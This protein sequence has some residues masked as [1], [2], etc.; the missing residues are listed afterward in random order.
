VRGRLLLGLLLLA[1]LGLLGARVEVT[2][3]LG[4]LLPDDGELQQAMRDVQ[5]FRLADTVL[6]EVDGTGEERRA[7]LAATDDL[8]ERLRTIPQIGAVRYRVEVDDGVALRAVALPHAA[9]LLPREVLAERLSDAGLRRALSLQLQ[10]LAGPGGSLFERSFLEDPLDLGGLT[11][12]H[13]RSAASPFAIRVADGHFLDMSGTRALITLQPEVPALGMG[14]DHPLIAALS[15]AVDAG[16]LPARWFGGHRLSSEAAGLIHKDVARSVQIGSVLLIGVCL[17]GF[18]SLRPVLG[19]A[20]PVG[21]ASAAGAAAAA[22]LSPVHGISLGFSAALLGLAIDYW[23]HLYVAA[24]AR[25]PEGADGA[26]RRAAAREALEE[27]L[28]GLLIG[29]GSTAGACAVLTLSRY[30][31]VADLGWMGVAATLGALA[32][33]VLLGPPMFGLIGRRRAA[34]VGANSA[35]IGALRVVLGSITLA[36][37][38]GATDTDVDGDPRHLAPAMAETR[39][40]EEEL[41]ARYGGFGTGGLAVVRGPDLEAVTDRLDAVQRALDALPGVDAVGPSPVLPGPTTRA[42]RRAALPDVASLQ[43]RVDSA[44]AALGFAPAALAGV[45][46][47]AVSLPA[48]TLSPA[49]W[50]QTPLAAL[51][52]QRLLPDGTG[53]VI[54]VVLADDGLAGVAE[55]AV[56]AS[57]GGEAA[58]V[59]TGGLA[60]DGVEDILAELVRL[61]GLSTA[62]VLGLLIA[63]Y[64]EPRKV[65][66]AAAPCAVA[67]VWALGVMGLTGTPWNAVS[68]CGLIFVLGLGLDHGVFMVEG[69]GRGRARETGTAVLLSALTTIGGFAALAFTQSPALFGLGL[70]VPAGV[71][72]ALATA[73]AVVPALT[74]GERVA[75]RWLR[76][77]ALAVLV[78]VDL[79]LIAQQLFYLTPPPAGP[80]PDDWTLTTPAPGDRRLGPN[81]LLQAGGI[82]TQ[83][84][85]G[86]AYA[87]GYAGAVLAP[88]LRERLEKQTLVSFS[89]NVPSFLGRL[90]ILR[91]TG[92][93]APRLDRFILPEHLDEI[94]GSVDAGDDLF[95]ML[96]PAYTRKVYYHAIHD[97][98]QA[99]VDAPFVVGCTGFMAGPGSTADGHWLLARNFDFDGGPIF[100]RDKVVSFVRPDEGYASVSVGFTGFSGVVSGLNERGL[101]VAINAAGSDDPPFAGTPMTLIIREILERA[102][103]IE[104]AEDILKARRG[105]VSENVMVVDGASGAAALFE[106]S[107]ERIGRLDV[108]GDLG[109]AN[110]FRT[111]VFADDGTNAWRKAELTSSH[112]QARMAALL[113]QHR[114]ALDMTR[115][116]EILRD[117]RAPDGA[118]LPPGHRW[119]IDA[120]IATHSVVIDATARTLWVS[121]YP[122]TAGGYVGYQLD[123]ALAGEIEPEEVMP[124]GDL[125]RTV[126]LHRGRA[127]LKEGRDDPVATARLALLRMPDHPQPLKALGTALVERGDCEEG[128]AVLERALATPPEY[129]EQVRDIEAALEVCP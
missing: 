15:E 63:R 83:L 18:R 90:L 104:E 88:D 22:L 50:S 27:I 72:G 106:V 87:R 24:A 45:A 9:T 103:S 5:R 29:A 14:P 113:D 114:G 65:L 6:I 69:V 75:P 51:A 89:E 32:G 116:V 23:I 91:G 115:A 53:G 79:D 67:T 17:L 95:A 98:G 125:R 81:R 44:G 118:V 60:R 58:L 30:P 82:W 11:L 92:L 57:G 70:S 111:A 26:A 49:H 12:R 84:T 127:L 40:L 80:V 97:I 54:S 16:A 94:R 109:V 62:L 33:T 38:V 112:R 121:R 110:H 1:V 105:F 102:A 47:R 42:E 108:A 2:G 39:A 101:A 4:R 59:T 99:V 43:A 31:V 7:L 119:A 21:L 85:V 107:P 66:A 48:E 28:P 41:S 73:L 96:G 46:A 52:G 71:T 117:R 3:D 77:A 37:I 74:R 123:R 124:P 76:R 61:G 86:S 13:L 36:A 68:A 64:R 19:A 20:G 56:R 55:A 25:A 122:N 93:W 129:A 78:I 100:D 128:R 10:R 8:G 35:P 126:E 120:D 34:A